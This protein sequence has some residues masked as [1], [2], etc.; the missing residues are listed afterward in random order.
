MFEDAKA[1]AKRLGFPTFSSYVVQLIRA[2]LGSGSS[3]MLI[4][5]TTTT[6]PIT[7]K[8]EDTTYA[9]QKKPPPKNS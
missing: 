8:R 7:T 1:R 5:E 3:G 4:Q 9:P 2:D 6:P